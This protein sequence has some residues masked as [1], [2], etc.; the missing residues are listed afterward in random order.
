MGYGL[1]LGEIRMIVES[2]GGVLWYDQTPAATKITFALP[3][4]S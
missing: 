2:M 3:T 1:T 4:G